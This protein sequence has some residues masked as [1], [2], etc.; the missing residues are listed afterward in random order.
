MRIRFLWLPA[1]PACLAATV[2]SGRSR[3]RSG[4]HRASSGPPN[5]QAKLREFAEENT[6]SDEPDPLTDNRP[7]LRIAAP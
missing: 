3:A 7:H 2:V 5:A 4:S 6:M 1:T